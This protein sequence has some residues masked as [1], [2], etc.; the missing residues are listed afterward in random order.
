MKITVSNCWVLLTNT[1]ACLIILRM[2]RKISETWCHWGMDVYS[3]SKTDLKLR[4]DYCIKFWLF[5][6]AQDFL[7]DLRLFIACYYNTTPTDLGQYYK[8]H[9]V[10]HRVAVNI[11]FVDISD[12]WALDLSEFYGYSTPLT[13]FLVNK[14]FASWASVE[15]STNSE[16]QWQR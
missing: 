13:T 7:V 10:G 1:T 3:D 12:F 6:G 11:Y 16:L 14:V 2:T 8:R 5:E 4:C 9:S 15:I